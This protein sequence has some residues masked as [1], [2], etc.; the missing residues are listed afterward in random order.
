MVTFRF[1]CY[2]TDGTHLFR[3]IDTTPHDDQLCLEDCATETR[4]WLPATGL[5]L[6]T[7]HP[8]PSETLS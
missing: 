1:G 8:S 3:V 5:Q 7:P 2:V 4:A 6:V